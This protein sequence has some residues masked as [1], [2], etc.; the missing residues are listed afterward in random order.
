MISSHW[1]RVVQ[2]S[3]AF[4]HLQRFTQPL[5]HLHESSSRKVWAASGR[6]RVWLVPS[7]LTLD[8]S[9]TGCWRQYWCREQHL[10]LTMTSLVC[11]PLYMFLQSSLGWWNMLYIM[12][13]C[14]EFPSSL[15]YVCACGCPVIDQNDKP[16]NGV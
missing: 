14:K 2:S 6:S 4:L 8:P 10:A 13:L 5:L 12:F 1:H 15:V 11:C 9:P 3:A 16:L 7:L